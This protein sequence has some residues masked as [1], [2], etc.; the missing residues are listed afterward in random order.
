MTPIDSIAKE[1]PGHEDFYKL[2]KLGEFMEI[3]RLHA[4]T[5][6][7]INRQLTALNQLLEVH[8]D[9]FLKTDDKL[10]EDIG[11]L[12]EIL[13]E[14]G[15]DFSAKSA[16]RLESRLKESK[17]IDSSIQYLISELGGRLRDEF[18][19][20]YVFMIP[21]TTERYYKPA[22]SI[23]GKDVADLFD[24]IED[25]D[26]AGN[27]FAL[28][29]NTACVFHLMRVMER[30]VQKFGEKLEILLITQKGKPLGWQDILNAI[31][32]PIKNMDPHNETTKIYAAIASHLYNVKLAWR[33]EVMH[34][35]ATY[36]E[37][38]AKALIGA[39]DVFMKDLVKIL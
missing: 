22:M 5:F 15:F 17:E 23:F 25:I 28:G 24:S 19:I 7:E 21:A 26:E 3:I 20:R 32:T 29:R 13:L 34:P 4:E 16:K 18:K 36:T 30:G 33:N 8:V 14:M 38:E 12:Y 31:N 39:V 35:K 11:K 1:N 37:E 6:I 10:T 2:I 9:L 27:C